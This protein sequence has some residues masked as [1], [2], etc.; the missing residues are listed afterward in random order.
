VPQQLLSPLNPQHLADL[1]IPYL[2]QLEEEQPA[3][4][5]LLLKIESNWDFSLP[6]TDMEKEEETLLAVEEVAKVEEHQLLH[7]LRPHL[8]QLSHKQ[9]I[10]KPWEPLQGYSKETVQKQK[11]S[12]INYEITTVSTEKSLDSTPP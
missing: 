6:Y 2:Y 11:T 4:A 7:S 10:S 3:L 1:S 9:L 12:S 8:R 5:G